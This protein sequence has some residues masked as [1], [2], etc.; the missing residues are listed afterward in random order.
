METLL[1]GGGFRIQQRRKRIK[2]IVISGR[3]RS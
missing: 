3:R 2:N 1:C